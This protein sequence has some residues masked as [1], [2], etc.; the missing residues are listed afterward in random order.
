MKRNLVCV[1]VCSELS[2]CLC[3]QWLVSSL[4][5]PASASINVHV[6]WTIQLNRNYRKFSNT[7][8]CL[9]YLDILPCS[10][11]CILWHYCI[12]LNVIWEK[13]NQQIRTINVC[14]FI[15]HVQWKYEVAINVFS[16]LHSNCWSRND[17]C[18]FGRLV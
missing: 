15:S 13:K 10:L 16:P 6:I 8:S 4:L 1:C 11:Y 5:V 3:K 17:V 18:S 12:Y 7:L 2:L 9:K 14:Y